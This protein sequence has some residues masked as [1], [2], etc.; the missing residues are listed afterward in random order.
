MGRVATDLQFSQLL[1][2]AP[3]LNVAA[4]WRAILL[5]ACGRTTTPL[6]IS[7]KLALR[8]AHSKLL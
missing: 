7:F 8:L 1:T 5:Q 2:I 4:H 6:Q 3:V